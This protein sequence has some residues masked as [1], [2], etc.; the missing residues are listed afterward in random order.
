VTGLLGRE[1]EARWRIASG[2]W[3][4]RVFAMLMVAPVLAKIFFP[5]RGGRSNLLYEGGLTV[6]GAIVLLGL[7][8]WLK[9]GSRTAA[10]LLLASFIALK[11]ALWWVG[12]AKLWDGALV[13]AA[14]IFGF[15]Q[16]IWGAVMLASV[17]RDRAALERGIP[18]KTS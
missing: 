8:E 6:A 7:S 18:G 12:A 3:T 11:L 9:R 15:V 5:G 10:V 4:G 13:A 1:G 16:G 17:R 2:V 14:L